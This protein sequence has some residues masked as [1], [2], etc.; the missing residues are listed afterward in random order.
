MK[1][2]YI[3]ILS[4]LLAI[5]LDYY[6][7]IDKKTKT[8]PVTNEVYVEEPIKTETNT[9]QEI[10]KPTIDKSFDTNDEY[11]PSRV[12]NE[13]YLILKWYLKERVSRIN[14]DGVEAI[15]KGEEVEIVS[16][17]GD[18]VTIKNKKGVMFEVSQSNLTND[19]PITS[20]T[21]PHTTNVIEQPPPPAII[22][23]PATDDSA[24]RAHNER[25]REAIKHIDKKIEDLN[26]EIYTIQ[27]NDA[28]RR[29]K[30]KITSTGVKV[31]RIKMQIEEL[32][33][34]KFKLINQIK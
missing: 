23:P 30:G 10:A 11:L 27:N 33:R 1:V 25:V 31:S 24:I 12:E 18:N 29:S 26:R 21:Q 9:P 3:V 8:V 34:N 4:L 13:K 17:S 20:E 14:E 5:A 22:P 16:R 32:E 19:K 15:G 28:F 6:K 7:K 2:I